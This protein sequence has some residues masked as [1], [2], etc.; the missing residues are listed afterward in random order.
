MNPKIL[1]KIRHKRELHNPNIPIWKHN[2]AIIEEKEQ[3]ILT[4]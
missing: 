3:L 1:A 2:I 4:Q